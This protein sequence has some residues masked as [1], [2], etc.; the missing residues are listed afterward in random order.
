MVEFHQLAQCQTP[1]K[2]KHVTKV[3]VYHFHENTWVQLD[4]EIKRFG[5][6]IVK[7]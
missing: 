3:R 5:V 1:P 2:E 4:I 7:N 6:F